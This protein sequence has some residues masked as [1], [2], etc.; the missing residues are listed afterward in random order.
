MFSAWREIVA[1]NVIM[2]ICPQVI[3]IEQF[4]IIINMLDE[5]NGSFSLCAAPPSPSGVSRNSN[6][7]W[8]LAAS[9]AFELYE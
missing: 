3:S 7:D 4:S 9:V 5:G 1:G 6:C 8:M 2:I